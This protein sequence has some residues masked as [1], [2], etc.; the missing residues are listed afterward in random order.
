MPRSLPL[1]SDLPLTMSLTQC[2][3]EQ[4]V[5]L[6]R[7]GTSDAFDEL[8]RRYGGQV[9]ALAQRL[10]GQA[11]AWDVA[12]EAFLAAYRGLG[13]FRGHS[14]LG[15]WLYRITLRTAYGAARRS[16]PP[17]ASQEPS[18][19]QP[20]PEVAQGREMGRA[21]EQALGALAWPQRAVLVLR[22]TGGLS[23]SQIAQV[24]GCQVGTVRSRLFYARE[25]LRRQL[26]LLGY[27]DD[28]LSF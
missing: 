2:S 3:D 10:V 23:Y 14:A 4:L 17:L 21:L 24:L 26:A 28:D 8:V 16:R 9:L 12:Q 7:S 18:P 11:S 15:T 27:S 6:A 25:Q 13:S 22:A 20:P 5:Y 1:A 19:V